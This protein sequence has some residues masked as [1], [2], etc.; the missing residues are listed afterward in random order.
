MDAHSITKL[1]ELQMKDQIYTLKH[2]NNHSIARFHV[3]IFISIQKFSH[4]VKSSTFQKQTTSELHSGDSTCKFTYNSQ[5]GYFCDM[6][7]N[8]SDPLVELLLLLSEDAG[9]L[10]RELN[11][12]THFCQ[13]LTDAADGGRQ[14]TAAGHAVGQLSLW[15]DNKGRE[16]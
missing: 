3:T 15:R 14:R 1:L 16:R 12:V 7:V 11:K 4:L 10:L 5:P 8:S 9:D 6:W 13:L 2:T